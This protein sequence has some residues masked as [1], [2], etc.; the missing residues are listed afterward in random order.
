MS[1][2]VMALSAEMRAE[3]REPHLLVAS[4]R[5]V[6]RH[7]A[8][9][10]AAILA[11]AGFLSAGAGMPKPVLPPGR[12]WAM[13]T[14]ANLKLASS[15][16]GLPGTPYAY[17]IEAAPAS[18]IAPGGQLVRLDLSSGR[19]SGGPRVPSASA[20]AVI[21]QRMAVLVPAGGHYELRLVVGVGAKVKLSAGVELDWTGWAPQL[22]DSPLALV[23]GGIWLASAHGAELFSVTTGKVLAAL[24]FRAE[25]SDLS[26]SPAGDFVY[27]AL[28]ELERHPLDKVSTMVD[29]FDAITGRLLA[30]HGIDF[31]VGPA[32]LTPVPGGVWVAYRTGMAGSAVLFRSQ[33]LE[34]APYPAPPRP[35]APVPQY[36]SGQIMGYWAAY[37]GS[38]LWVQSYGGVSCVVPATG[39]QLAGVAF[40][41]KSAVAEY[42]DLFA[43]WGSL[44]YGDT[45]QG[46]IAIR[47]AAAC[48]LRSAGQALRALGTQGVG[49]TG[50]G[51][52]K[53]RAVYGPR[54]A[55]AALGWPLADVATR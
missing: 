17:A 12:P 30:H 37:L 23:R 36:G 3:G 29:E 9:L 52:T 34:Q 42:W 24:G 44:V 11:I 4:Y 16:V 32:V 40:S 35:F 33:G 22:I 54:P 31:G 46:I 26:E 27:V 43:T 41:P 20:L 47:A 7:L 48:H 38:D 55:V 2:A 21:G 18:P 15:P 51:T 49:R 13:A 10:G 5:D 14:V 19:V 39:E 50:F 25:V 45:P 53:A 6:L 28:D 1:P 8:R